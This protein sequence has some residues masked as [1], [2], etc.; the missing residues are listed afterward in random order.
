MEGVPF[1]VQYFAKEYIINITKKKKKKKK[2]ALFYGDNL[3]PNP[4]FE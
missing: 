4:L 2:K 1:Q 3:P